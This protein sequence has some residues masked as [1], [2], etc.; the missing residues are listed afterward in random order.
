MIKID[1]ILNQFFKIFHP[2]K[3]RNGMHRKHSNSSWSRPREALRQVVRQQ[4]GRDLK[5]QK[6]RHYCLR[7]PLRIDSCN[8]V[9]Y[10][11][12]H[13]PI[14]DVFDRLWNYGRFEIF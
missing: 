12:W 6:Q 1:K 7:F 11:C 13:L 8:Y 10:V 5:R 9:F 2:Q 3:S 14:L 4:H